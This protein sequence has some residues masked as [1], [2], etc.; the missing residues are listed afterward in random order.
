MFQI[1]PDVLRSGNLAT[2]QAAEALI[3]AQTYDQ[4]G[5]KDLTRNN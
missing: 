2:I 3:G 4:W 5:Q 1:H